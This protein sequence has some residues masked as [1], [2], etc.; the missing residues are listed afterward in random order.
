MTKYYNI[1]EAT[2]EDV[3]DAEFTR[4]IR[5]IFPG[6][7][8]TKPARGSNTDLYIHSRPAYWLPTDKEGKALVAHP[9]E[10]I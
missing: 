10:I 2:I 7:T 3:D 6:Q 5:C 8:I 4:E 1:L 9:I